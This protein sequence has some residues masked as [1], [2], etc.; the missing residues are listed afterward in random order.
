MVRADDGRAPVDI[1]VCDPL[2]RGSVLRVISPTNALRAGAP[3]F[4][5]ENG[6]IQKLKPLGSS[7]R[8]SEFEVRTYLV[9]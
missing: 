5:A 3:L 4:V 8:G 2:H 9:L 6:A 1:L 7:W